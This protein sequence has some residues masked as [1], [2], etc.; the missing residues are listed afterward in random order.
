MGK[1]FLLLI[2][3]GGLLFSQ[4]LPSAFF[5]GT[6]YAN[7]VTEGNSF[8]ALSNPAT[9]TQVKNNLGLSYIPK[10]YGINEISQQSYGIS[11]NTSFFSI[12]SVYQS[13]GFKLFNEHKVSIGIAKEIFENFSIGISTVFE[14]LNIQ[15]YGSANNTKINAGFLYIYNNNFRFGVSIKNILQIKRAY[16][17]HNS[18]NEIMLGCSFI[19]VEFFSFY[20][21]LSKQILKEVQFSLGG[22]LKF[23]D[24]LILSTGY[25]QNPN[26]LCYGLHLTLNLFEFNFSL[27]THDYL[28]ETMALDIILKI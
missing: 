28:K 19:P 24:S 23:F 5:S 15:N 20:F 22:R 10:L 4:V 2:I 12:N 6:A 7:S 3:Q 11:Y 27:I 26:I 1:V 14:H 25:S 18:D 9:I 8:S 21:K 13:Y 17:E 16:T